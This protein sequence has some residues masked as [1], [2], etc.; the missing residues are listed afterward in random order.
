MGGLSL[1]LCVLAWFI[2]LPLN[3]SFEIITQ[4][5]FDHTLSALS[6]MCSVLPMTLIKRETI[7][8]QFCLR[9]SIESIFIFA[10]QLKRLASRNAEPRS[11][12]ISMQSER[13]KLFSY[14]WLSPAT[15]RPEKIWPAKNWNKWAHKASLS[16]YNKKNLFRLLP[17]ALELCD[18]F[19]WNVANRATILFHFFFC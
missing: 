18:N 12:A 13:M 19:L 9:E 7:W 8:L 6:G 5:I 10:K 14:Y 11:S 17:I 4:A 15:V 2:I 3:Y 1:G 16:Q